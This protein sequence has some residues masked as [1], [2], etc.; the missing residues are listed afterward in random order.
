MFG[1]LGVQE[2]LI[3]FIIALF[4]FGG[5]KLPEVG[6]NLGKALRSFR[7]AEAETRRELEEAVK[8]PPP[9]EKTKERAEEGE[10][11]E[12]GKE[13]AQEADESKNKESEDA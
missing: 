8:E 3:V 2:L 6:Q 4:L 12:A 10:P 7:Q 5:K 11:E 13:A 9:E 1:G